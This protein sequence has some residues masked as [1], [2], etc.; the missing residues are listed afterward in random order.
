MRNYNEIFGEPK[1]AHGSMTLAELEERTET[2]WSYKGYLVAFGF[3]KHIDG[4]SYQ[5]VRV[6]KTDGENCELKFEMPDLCAA[7]MQAFRMAKKW[8]EQNI[9]KIA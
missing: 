2:I 9:N 3:V 8:A 4:W 1:K 7:D 5:T 6:W